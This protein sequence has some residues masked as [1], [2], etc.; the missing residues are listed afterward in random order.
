MVRQQLLQVVLG[1]VVL[2][3][4]VLDEEGIL[5]VLD[6]EEVIRFEV[7]LDEMVVCWAVLRAGKMV[8]SAAIALVAERRT[9]NIR[10]AN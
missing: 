6:E 5:K 9:T 1:Q 4:M 10:I 7:V 2:G 8:F 3:P